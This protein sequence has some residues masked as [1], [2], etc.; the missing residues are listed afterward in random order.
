ME[1]GNV[2]G[3]FGPPKTDKQRGFP[4]R[5]QTTDIFT[6]D[7]RPWLD[8]LL[9]KDSLSWKSKNRVLYCWIYPQNGKDAAG[10]RTFWLKS[11][12]KR[13][14]PKCIYVTDPSR[15]AFAH[16]LGI[17]NNGNDNA[18]FQNIKSSTFLSDPVKSY[19]PI[20]NICIL[21]KF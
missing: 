6:K 21:I 15:K 7:L 3:I 5:K 19:P 8:E 11:L 14:G 17:E 2:V 13:N 10:S 18:I 1:A 12:Q 9:E 16:A 4:S 20:E